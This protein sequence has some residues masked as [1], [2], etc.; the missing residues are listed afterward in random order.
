[1]TK[2]ILEF[3]LIGTSM[4]PSLKSGDQLVIQLSSSP[5]RNNGD[6]LFFKNTI[7]NDFTTHR[8][9][10]SKK[11]KLKG[12]N[13]ISCDQLDLQN[14]L[15]LGNV[16]GI[17][18]NDINIFWGKEGQPLKRLIAKASLARTKNN[19]TRKIA[20][21]VLLVLVKTSSLLCSLPTKNRT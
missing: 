4:E 2:D 8:M 6:I 9:I 11:S 13:S 20:K 7:L 5:S 14:T 10:D 3:P 15:L 16:I 21:I 12:D 17:K 1:M 18:R 19:L